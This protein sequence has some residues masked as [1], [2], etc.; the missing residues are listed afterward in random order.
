MILTVV[1]LAALII[2]TPIITRW[3]RRTSGWLLAVAYLAIA[4]LFTP[5]AAEVMSGSTP[6]VSF[7]WIPAFGVDLALRADGI[8]VIFTF[9]A[10]IIGAIVFVYSTAYLSPG[11]NTSFYWLMVIF[12]FSMVMLV[13]SN[14][15]LVLFVCWELT[16]LA[17]FFLIA[18]SGSPGQGPSLRTMFITFIGGLSL[19][20]A[21]GTI[22]AV[23]GTTNINEALSSPVWSGQAPVTTLVAILIA[24]AAMT[25][26]AQFP[27]HSWLPDAMAAA[28]PVSAYLHAAAVVKA[29]IFLL[30]RFTP[31]FH[32]TPAWNTLLI[33]A[34]LITACIGGW[35]ALHQYDVKKLMA[36]STVSQ[37]GLITA[38]I[39]IGS[40]AAIAAAILHV[41][42]HA[43]F[44]S[45]LFMMV[46]VIDHL[47]GTRELTR[48]PRLMRAAPVSFAVMIVGCASMAGIPPLLGFVSKE[49]LF[50]AFGDTPGSAWTAWAALLVA[51]GASVLTFAYCAKT[52][53]GAFID[54]KRVDRARLGHGSPVML[55]SAAVPIFASIP[56][57]FA[58]FVF[59]NPISQAVRASLFESTGPTDLALWHGVNAELIA[60]ALIIAVGVII[61]FNRSRVFVFFHRA[62]LGFDGADV[63]SGL[64]WVLRR[65]GRGLSI[66][67]KPMNS[68]P[69]LAM[70]LGGLAVLAFSAVPIIYPDLPPLQDGLW[71]PIDIVLLVLITIAV[72]VVCTSHSRL[73]TVVALSGVGI[74]AT[75]QILALGA[76]DVTL[77]QLLVEAMTII[78]IMLVLQKLPRSFWRYP[79]RLQAIRVIF[80]LVVGLA[81]T[82][83]TLALNGRR[84]R[85]DLG[86]Y[87]ID[88]APDISGGHNIVNTILVEFRALDTL[89][90][91]TVL[92]MAGI[93]IVA[94]MSTVKDKFIDPPAE[95]IPEPPRQAWISIRPRG[96]TAYRAVHEAWPNVIPQQLTIRV[97]GPLLAITSLVVF[98]RGHNE[99]GGG[100]IAALIGSAVI[101]LL[102]MSTAKDR[103]IGPPRA[104]LYLI[105]SGVATAVVTGLIGLIAVGSFL[106]PLHAEFLG[107]HF[108]TSML[109]D[110]G[111]YLAVL[112]LILA[113]FN[114]LGV[115]DSAATPAGDDV[116]TNGIIRRD[117]ERTRERADE[118]LYG[119]LSGPL[120]SIRGERPSRDR[121]SKDADPDA[122]VRASSTHILHGDAPV[123]R[124]SG[125]T[126]EQSPTDEQEAAKW[127]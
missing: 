112:G 14:D 124:S 101:G 100:F 89:G 126:A 63:M 69:Y 105:G 15:L 36:Y 75:V 97:L 111:V 73:T 93:A 43:L 44:K 61:I 96:T 107:Q 39:G 6:E 16:S 76:P 65:A 35:F 20:I 37:L 91:L 49:A 52:V 27:F 125:E 84:E 67:A 121:R 4:A 9:I 56:L 18:R 118:L 60:S 57:S 104:P 71:R 90:E 78:V 41:I 12:T 72:L 83:L 48:I 122:K 1:A 3:L 117:V 85:S 68:G 106:E 46:G 22:I 62:A 23:T 108:T 26:S 74:L 81:A 47:T 25:K 7:Q 45:G 120:D 103:A 29:G 92:G 21:T 32:A 19:L 38:V 109:F 94:V 80:A 58:L 113:S 127:S 86:L 10:L 55:V 8:G 88:N 79:K 53:W 40:E 30:L 115:S 11:R 66:F 123:E 98:W 59:D 34:G 54:G 82:V 77:T 99:P 64:T 5:T 31:A 50:T 116:L 70:S 28:T 87:Y 13:L 33:V 119:E 17:S 110:L 24:V 51:V 102:Y 2:V 114:L 95:N 42:A